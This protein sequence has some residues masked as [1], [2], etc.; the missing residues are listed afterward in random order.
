[1]ASQFH[2]LRVM[3]LTSNPDN[4][5][6][7]GAA[8]DA[9]NLTK[10][11]N[12][13]SLAMA[14]ARLQ[15]GSVDLIVADVDHGGLMVPSLLR[16]MGLTKRLERIPPILWVG[17]SDLV[18]SKPRVK[19][20]TFSKT[21]VPRIGLVDAAALMSLV[22]LAHQA[23]VSVEMVFGEGKVAFTE[24]VEKLL[25]ARSVNKNR[26]SNITPEAP[27]ESDVIEAL[28]TGRN[29]RV[30]LQ[31]QYDLQTRCVVGAEA[32]LRWHHPTYGEV[33]PS[34]LI[35]MVNRLGLHLLLFSFIE[36]RVIDVLLS[37]K[38][39]QAALSIA[40]NASAETVSTPGLPERLAEKMQ[41]A[42]LPP[43]LL[44]I[45]LTGDLASANELDLAASVQSLRSKGF[46]VS[47][48]DFGQGSASLNLLTK[49]P[50][51]E[52]KIDGSLVRDIETN[53]AA[54][55]VLAATVSLARLMNLTLIVEG[56]E[57]E[58]SIA[59]LLDLRCDIGQG[60][61]LARPMEIRDFFA[62]VQRNEPVAE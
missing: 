56:I 46:L 1:M 4:A 26:P 35:P 10:R 24:A 38:S 5:R 14:A 25:L 59:P 49:I 60:Y 53:P 23:G 11:D 39:H 28:T 44:K 20:K 2:A 7:L 41:R 19:S 50:F 17:L 30:M 47:L 16:S 29:L 31:P 8:L 13:P 45:E 37:L 3:T 6:R 55:I 52:I 34:V 43:A 48:D 61:A 22:R 54:R 36:A 42:G 12:V 62:H 18:D 51:D 9:A 40:L 58:S 27:S 15:E 57:E 21:E 33:P 32:L